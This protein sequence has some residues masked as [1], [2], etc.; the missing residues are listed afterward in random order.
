MNFKRLLPYIKPH[1]PYDYGLIV[2]C[3][4]MT[5][6][7]FWSNNAIPV[8]HRPTLIAFSQVGI[9]LGL[10]S[11]LYALLWVGISILTFF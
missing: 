6:L 5:S 9:G 1:P 8:D 11:H 7:P 3:L 2:I 4:V 10:N